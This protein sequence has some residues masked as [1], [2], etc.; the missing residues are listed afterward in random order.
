MKRQYIQ[1]ALV[2]IIL[3][4]KKFVATSLQVSNEAQNGVSGDVKEYGNQDNAS[5]AVN[6]WDEE[7]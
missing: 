2:Q 5:G 3:E 1:P 6:V 4:A 7:W